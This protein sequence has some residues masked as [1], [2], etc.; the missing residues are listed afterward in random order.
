MH[1]KNSMYLFE[2]NVILYINTYFI[3]YIK[4]YVINYATLFPFITKKKL[5]Y[6]KEL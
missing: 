6:K 2:I 4:L 5:N 3:K 1:Y